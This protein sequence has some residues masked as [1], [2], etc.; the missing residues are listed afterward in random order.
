MLQKSIT[1]TSAAY[2]HSLICRRLLMVIAPIITN[3]PN[4]IPVSS[5]LISDGRW[6][7][8]F[9]DISGYYFRRTFGVKTGAMARKRVV[10]VPTV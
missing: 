4:E 10:W 3:T 5:R 9:R 1:V 7:T 8:G 6:E 2:L